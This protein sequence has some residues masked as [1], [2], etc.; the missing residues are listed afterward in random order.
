MRI[1]GH[2][3]DII[4]TARIAAMLED[5]PERF[6]ERVFTDQEQQDSGDGRRR[7]EHLAARFAAKEAAFKAIGTGWSQGVG[8]TDVAVV[9]EA[10]GK[11]TL[12]ISGRT[13]EIAEG[14]GITHWHI[15]LSHTD[16][17][18]MAS[19]I[20]EGDRQIEADLDK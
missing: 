19:V 18:A 11:P 3:V 20:A 1:I 17:L 6:L 12:V 14:L 15:S 13:G 10:S 8:W 16:T 4:E 9:K 5:H 2:G 7:N